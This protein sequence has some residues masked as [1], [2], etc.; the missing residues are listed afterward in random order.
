MKQV[1]IKSVKA[2]GI[3]FTAL[4]LIIFVFSP[5]ALLKIAVSVIRDLFDTIEDVLNNFLDD[6]KP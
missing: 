5:V 6:M 3:L 2:Y 4:F 1:I